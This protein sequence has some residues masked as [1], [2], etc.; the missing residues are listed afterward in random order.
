MFPA[1]QE[2]GIAKNIKVIEWLKAD[3]MASASSLFKAMLRGSEER[4]LD[5][6]ASIVLTCYILGRRLGINYSRLDLRV[7]AKL[8]Q[9][10]DED[11]E[12]EKWY[13]DLSHLLR[14]F[15]EKKR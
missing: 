14:Y 4:L 11:H 1:D 10:I 15:V 5:A 8:R 2:P 13:G 7:E 6:L 12:V 3:L 9:S